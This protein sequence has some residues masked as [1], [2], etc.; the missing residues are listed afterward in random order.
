MDLFRLLSLTLV[1]GALADPTVQAQDKTG[2]LTQFINEYF[3]NQ[4]KV[5][6]LTPAERTT[7]E[8]FIRRVTLDLI[9]RTAT[10]EEV[11]AFLKTTA[12]DKRAQLVDKLLASHEFASHRATT[13]TNWLLPRAS[14]PQRYRDELH[15][16]LEDATEKKK[17]YQQT[18]TSLIAATGKNNDNG[19]ANFILGNLGMQFPMKDEATEGQYELVPATS[20]ILRLFL[21][22][23][24]VAFPLPDHPVH[25]DFK[26]EQFW[27]VNAFL[28]QVE[29]ASTPPAANVPGA[30]PVLDLR[31]NP[32]FNKQGTI[33]FK[34]LN[35]KT[36]TT[37]PVF[38]D[39]RKPTGDNKTRRQVLAEYVTSHPNFAKTY[40]NRMWG[41]FFGR[42]LH[43]RPAVDDFGSHHK[44]VHPEL[45]DRLAKDL[46]ASNYDA[47]QIV[48]QLCASDVYQLRSTTN[49]TNAKDEAEVY[50]SRMPLKLMTPEQ[51]VHSLFHAPADGK[52][53]PVQAKARRSAYDHITRRLGDQEWDD[54]PFQE[55]IIQNVVLIN[56]KDINDVIL[57]DKSGPVAR[58]LT[59]TTP[60]ATLEELYLTAL[61]RKPSE[62]EAAHIKGLIEKEK[63]PKEL[64]QLWQDLYWA[65]INSSEFIL[66]H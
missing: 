63:D 39:G 35:G 1:A 38:L 41:H 22:Y 18:V 13:W 52:L 23:R 49:A 20:R 3:A 14:T 37:V 5:Q 27:G 64:T 59:L 32:A 9:G 56:R 34:D 54:L 2:S 16:W 30:L 57:T 8:E 43:E 61:N 24:I 31:D 58:A 47:K 15:L 62:K 28:R 51:L 25:P 36:Q 21:G 45:L 60:E 12:A 66:N 46:V 50:F 53:V 19:A 65:L 7:D 26:P 44:L 10:P 17:N 48:R 33:T 42:G 29:R 11:R 6:K 40:A 55:R 4:W